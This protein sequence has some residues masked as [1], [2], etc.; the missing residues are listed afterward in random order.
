[1]LVGVSQLSN[2]SRNLWVYHLLNNSHMLQVWNIYLYT[3]TIHLPYISFR[4]NVGTYSILGS[5]WDWVPPAKLSQSPRKAPLGH[6]G[7]RRCSLMV[8][9]GDGRFTI[10]KTCCVPSEKMFQICFRGSKYLLRC[11]SSQRNEEVPHV[12]NI[13]S[14]DVFR[15]KKTYCW[16]V[17][18]PGLSDWEYFFRY[19]KQ[20]HHLIHLLYQNIMN[21][22]FSACNINNMIQDVDSR[23]F[24]PLLLLCREFRGIRVQGGPLAVVISRAITPINGVTNG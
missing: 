15:K 11:G 14:L 5:I 7:P 18:V 9:D 22:H 10:P 19:T 3:F 2:W 1:M 13:D 17:G 23:I 21:H 24:R 6:K 16:C 20:N 8:E 12:R 4:S